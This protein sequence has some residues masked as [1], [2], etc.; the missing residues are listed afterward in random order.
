[1]QSVGML[2]APLSQRTDKTRQIIKRIDVYIGL[3]ITLLFT[4]LFSFIQP[5]QVSITV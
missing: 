2:D 5:G 1:M 3:K 4:L